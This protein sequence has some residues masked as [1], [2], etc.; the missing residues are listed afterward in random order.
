MNIV[1]Y[2]VNVKLSPR[3]E[4]E[5][6]LLLSKLKS[7]SFA[8]EFRYS[9]KNFQRRFCCIFVK[10]NS[11]TEEFCWHIKDLVLL[12]NNIEILKNR[13]NQSVLKA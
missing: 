4:A 3:Y 9:F 7:E 12:S 1:N 8:D 2:S 10:N 6:Q 11:F 5:L 13:F